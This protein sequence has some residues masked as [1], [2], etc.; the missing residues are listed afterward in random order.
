MS[1]LLTFGHFFNESLFIPIKKMFET[2]EVPAMRLRRVASHMIKRQKIEHHLE[3]RTLLF[4]AIIK[5]GYC[6]W[7]RLV[8]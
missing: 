6:T 7:E 4:F 2:S 1:K 8:A 5:C 3:R